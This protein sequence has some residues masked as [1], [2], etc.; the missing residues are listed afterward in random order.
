MARRKENLDA[1]VRE[2]HASGAKAVSYCGAVRDGATA[3]GAVELA[4][5]T[6]GRLDVAFNNVGI[7]G[8]AGST[9]DIS[10]EGWNDTPGSKLFIA[11]L[12]APK[13]VAIDELAQTAHYLASDASS[14]TTGNAMLVDGGLSINR[15]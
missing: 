8:P 6:F 13:R 2:P 9:T 3:M 11:G 1:L 14:F 5:K 7:R 4:V 15:T 10:L 12:H